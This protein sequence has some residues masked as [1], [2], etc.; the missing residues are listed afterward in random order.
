[1]LYG[2]DKVIQEEKLFKHKKFKIHNVYALTE[3]VKSCIKA[4]KNWGKEFG[5]FDIESK[6]SLKPLANQRKVA[7]KLEVKLGQRYK[8]DNIEVVFKDEKEN[9]KDLP[10]NYKN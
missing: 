2:L 10:E 4:I 7:I 1:M 9:I 6:F 3:R 5:F 8:L